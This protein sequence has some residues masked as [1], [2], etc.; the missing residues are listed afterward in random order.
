MFKN[1][2]PKSV[3]NDNHKTLPR[4]KKAKRAKN[5]IKQLKSTDLV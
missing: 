1:E 3:Q 5:Q 2:T 4:A